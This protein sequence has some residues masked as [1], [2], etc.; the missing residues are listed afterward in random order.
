MTTFT[1]DDWKT[2]IKLLEAQ[3]N[4]VIEWDEFGPDKELII[5]TGLQEDS[6]GNLQWQK[7]DCCHDSEGNYLGAAA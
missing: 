4:V 5:H 2:F 7:C 1:L 3:P 6:D